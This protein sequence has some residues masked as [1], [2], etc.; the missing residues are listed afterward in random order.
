MKTLL[1]RLSISPRGLSILLT[2]SLLSLSFLNLPGFN[3]AEG[4][5]GDRD[6]FPDRRQ[7]GGTHW[8]MP[9]VKT[10]LIDKA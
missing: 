8:V 2:V 5:G 1:I 4:E 7:G 3:L 6:D 10:E 9:D